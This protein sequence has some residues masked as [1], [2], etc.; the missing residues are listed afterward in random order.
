MTTLRRRLWRLWQH[1]NPF[2]PA[3][4]MSVLLAAAWVLIALWLTDAL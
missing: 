1:C 3:G 2:T 4:W